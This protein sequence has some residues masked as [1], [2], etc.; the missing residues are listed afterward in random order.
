[1]K[2]IGIS[3]AAICMFALSLTAADAQWKGDRGQ[4]SRTCRNE[5]EAAC[6]QRCAIP[7]PASHFREMML[8]DF[9]AAK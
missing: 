6:V 3:L 9:A 8:S 7:F 5:T 4:S 1:M 2:T